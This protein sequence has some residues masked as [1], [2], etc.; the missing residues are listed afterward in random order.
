MFENYLAY[1]KGWDDAFKVDP[2]LPINIDIEL[3]SLC[4]L[5]CPFCFWGEA[6]FNVQMQKHADDGRPRKRLMPTVMALNIIDEAAR[7]GVPA[8]KFNW[9]GES[10]LHPDYSSILQ[11]ARQ[12]VRVK[13]GPFSSPEPAF[14]DLIVNT[15]ANCKDHAIDGLMAATKTIIS[16]DSVIP[17]VYARSRVNGNLERAIEVTKELIRRGH[18]NLWIRRV[19]T[20]ENQHEQFKR[21]VDKIFG[22]E[23]YKVSEH[24][25]F[26]RSTDSVHESDSAPALKRRYCGYPSQRLMISSDG[27]VYPCCVDYDGDMPMGKW[28]GERGGRIVDI[29]NN[30]KF[31]T[32]RK[33]LRGD[34]FRS[35]ICKGCTSWL[36]YDSP[37]RDKVQDKAV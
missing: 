4:N 25:C 16:L 37:K 28:T 9:R 6:D 27:T 1:R 23:G 19:I 24:F 5:A 7:T 21:Q 36:A 26:D 29:W 22:G 15:N 20:K 34:I 12:Y 13:R 14:F 32:L 30:E 35:R 33:E 17:E 8:L 2:P 18:P 31:R 3:A 10:T 11:H